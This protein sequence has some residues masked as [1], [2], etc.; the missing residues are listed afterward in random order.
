LPW[1]NSYILNKWP[2][3]KADINEF[4]RE[5]FMSYGVAKGYQKL[6]DELAS[7]DDRQRLIAIKIDQENVKQLTTIKRG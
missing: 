4:Q 6:V 5:Y 3:P 2:D 1:L 7:A